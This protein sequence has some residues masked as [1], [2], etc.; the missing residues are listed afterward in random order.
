MTYAQY[1][2]ERG[3]LAAGPQWLGLMVGRDPL[4]CPKGWIYLEHGVATAAQVQE[5][6]DAL[7]TGRS[8][9]PPDTRKEK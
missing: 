9:W 3:G 2:A 5:A 8:Q 6:L 1:L 4:K 7:C